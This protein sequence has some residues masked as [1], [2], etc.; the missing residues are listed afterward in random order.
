MDSDGRL[1]AGVRLHL[2]REALKSCNV[3]HENISLL[4]KIYRDQKASVQ[5]DEESNI[6]NI[7]KGPK[8]G[9]PMPSLLFNMVL[10][11]S[12]K[13]YNDGKRKKEWEYT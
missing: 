12:L 9:D 10:Q 3:D 7:Q 4:R 13:K 1:H 2:S 11:Y 5:T 8:Q 6:F